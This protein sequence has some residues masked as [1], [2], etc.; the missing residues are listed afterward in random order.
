MRG[1]I[2]TTPSIAVFI[3][4]IIQYLKGADR[5]S[6]DTYFL[7]NERL[8]C[9]ETLGG[10]ITWFQVS[11]FKFQGSGAAGFKIQDSEQRSCGFQDSG[12]RFQDSEQR[13]CWFQV[14]RFKIQDSGALSL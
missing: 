10:F 14:S 7:L 4:F 13:S 11:G 12:F 9:L 1:S 8:T 6:F 5:S 2:I 3:M